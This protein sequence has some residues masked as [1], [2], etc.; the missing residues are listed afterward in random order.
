MKFQAELIVEP[1]AFT[2]CRLPGSSIIYG[3]EKKKVRNCR[4]ARWSF[5]ISF[6]T[7]ED[8]DPQGTILLPF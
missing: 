4:G 5:C 8:R 1:N 6:L 3:L 2:Q 7:A